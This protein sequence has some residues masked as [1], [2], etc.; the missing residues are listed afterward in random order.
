MRYGLIGSIVLHILVFGFVIFNITLSGKDDAPPP[1]PVS[2]EVMSPKDFS[3][4]Q[5]GKT[6]GKAEKP[7]PPAEVKAPD[8]AANA[9][10]DV[11]A[12]AV[13]EAGRKRSACAS[14]AP[15]SR[16]ARAKARRAG[17]G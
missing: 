5:A 10:K 11:R 9:K 16:A 14:A 12:E 4:R 15:E 17:Q 2:V 1:A 7:A 8:A 3:E 13:S 6:D